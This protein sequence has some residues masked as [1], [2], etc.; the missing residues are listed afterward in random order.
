L[1]STAEISQQQIPTGDVNVDDFAQMLNSS[2]PGRAGGN[3]MMR[4]VSNV[5]GVLFI[6]VGLVGFASHN[7]M[8]MHLNTTHNVIHLVTGALS[9]YFGIKGTDYA[10]RTWCKTAGIVYV[11]FGVLG[12]LF[13]PG[14]FTL[15]GL[16]GETTNH[17]FKVI[18]GH[19][20]FGTGD[21]IVHTIV[22]IIYAITGFVPRRVERRVDDTIEASKE[23]VQSGY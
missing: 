7:L 4:T 11:F 16:A 9:L 21:S 8:G 18:P 2:P 12:L 13:G 5:L 19:L 15:R 14:M 6:L 23:R 22:G 10:V 20:E 3:N 1:N 17:L